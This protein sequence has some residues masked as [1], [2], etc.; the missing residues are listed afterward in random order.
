MG[1][2]GFL[3]C[4]SER[5]GCHGPCLALWC[6]AKRSATCIWDCVGILYFGLVD[7]VDDVLLPPSAHL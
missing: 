6:L 5:G 1:A 2:T 4:M 7:V 3:V